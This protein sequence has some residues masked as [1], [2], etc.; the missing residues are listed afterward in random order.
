[1]R[2]NR[3][4]ST[5]VKELR[6]RFPQ[7]IILRNDSDYLQGVPDLTILFNDRWAALEV[8]ASES[9]PAQPNQNFYISLF[10]E[11]SWAA[12]IYPENQDDVLEALQ[13]FLAGPR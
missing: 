6:F 4:Q 13:V 1:M 9:A 11:M 2:E 7:C 10:N 3:Y 12:F 5:L 8:K